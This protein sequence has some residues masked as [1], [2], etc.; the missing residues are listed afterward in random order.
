MPAAVVSF[1]VVVHADA[2][3]RPPASNNTVLFFIKGF[4]G[5]LFKVLL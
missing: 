2:A 3:V 4:L 5:K 1:W